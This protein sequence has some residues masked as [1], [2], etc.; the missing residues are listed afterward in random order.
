M[1]AL[2]STATPSNI[3]TGSVYQRACV[4]GPLALSWRL[5]LLVDQMLRGKEYELSQGSYARVNISAQVQYVGIV[6]YLG[7]YV[8]TKRLG[9][10]GAADHACFNA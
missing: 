8:F 1:P 3:C 4:P 9:Q 5:P 2:K 10:G 7:R 6:L